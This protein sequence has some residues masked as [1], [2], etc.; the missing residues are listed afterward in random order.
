MFLEIRALKFAVPLIGILFFVAA[1]SSDS[2]SAGGPGNG[3]RSS[4]ELQAF[5]VEP[6][7]LASNATGDGHIVQV[8]FAAA[9]T[10]PIERGSGDTR[11]TF[12]DGT[13]YVLDGGDVSQ[14]SNTDSDSRS[15]NV[16]FLPGEDSVRIFID[17]DSASFGIER[18]A[19][20]GDSDTVTSQPS[21]TG[22]TGEPFYL[23]VRT[24]TP[25]SVGGS[26]D[27]L[28]YGFWLLGQDAV[29]SDND[30]LFGA[31]VDSNAGI[32]FPSNNL[33]ALSGEATYEGA[34][35]GLYYESTLGVSARFQEFQA[36]VLLEADFGDDDDL[37]SITGTIHSFTGL[38][39]V[40]ADR[41]PG[42]EVDLEEADLV[43]RG[44][45]LFT[46]STDG[47]SRLEGQWGGKFY[48]DTATGDA[49]HP[50]TVAGTFGFGGEFSGDVTVAWLGVYWADLEE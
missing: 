17:T 21:D 6:S 42:L 9:N 19:R 25:S 13:T 33:E 26:T 24:D 30:P 3:G 14:S 41:W 31:F 38:N 4:G 32:V 29:Q 5:F 20:R 48:D 11:V 1:C 16:R 44:G 50:G 47:P 39:D 22:S 15:A 23:Y 43:D 36:R 49:D 35:D 18:G 10:R 27:Y 37:G 46:G 7:Q 34:A 8:A 2:G 28:A 45:G 12:D 40:Y